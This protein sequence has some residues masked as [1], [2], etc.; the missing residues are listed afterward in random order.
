MKVNSRDEMMSAWEQALA[1]LTANQADLPHVEDQGVELAA[2]LEELR[3]LRSRKAL[4]R[5]EMSSNTQKLNDV[6][7]RGND[8]LARVRAGARGW[9]GRRSEKLE[10]F[11]M[12]PL[13]RRGGGGAVG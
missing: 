6:V 9:Y 8:L 2:T 10:E 7:A 1:A 13:R 5:E 12:K 4:L 3:K 11:G